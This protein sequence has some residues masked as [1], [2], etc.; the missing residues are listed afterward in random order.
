MMSHSFPTAAYLVS[1]LVYSV[2][3]LVLGFVGGALYAARFIPGRVP[4]REILNGSGR[5]V[6]GLLILALVT[7]TF[8]RGLVDERRLE[9][10][11]SC[12]RQFNT[13]YRTVLQ[14]N[15]AAQRKF[16]AIFTKPEAVTTEQRAAAFNDYFKSLRDIPENNPCG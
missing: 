15:F 9:A 3:G 14:N 13:T 6:V 10:Q 7:L 2:A 11:V 12:Q 1:S 4:R 16:L 8:V 5:L